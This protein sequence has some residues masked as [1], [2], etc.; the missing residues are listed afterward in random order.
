MTEHRKEYLKEYNKRPEV[1]E[2]LRQKRKEQK[3]DRK[4]YFKKY[5]SDPKNIAHRAEYA[6]RYRKVN[7]IKVNSRRRERISK[8]TKWVYEIKKTKKCI[9]C[10]FDKHP[11]ALVFHHKN[12][13]EKYKTIKDLVQSC[14][15]KKKILEEMEKCDV[16]CNNCHIIKHFEEC[17]NYK[18]YIS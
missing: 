17:K 13:D 7:R 5:L 10:N 1:K 14:C 6:K 18:F 8:L 2:R 9:L 11:A 15:S 3:K 4:E 12:K 16:L